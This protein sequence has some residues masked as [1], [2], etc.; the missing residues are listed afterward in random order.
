MSGN[1]GTVVSGLEPLIKICLS[2]KKPLFMSDPHSVERGA[3]SAYAYDQ[4]KI[5]QQGGSHGGKNP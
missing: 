1:Y 4:R 2:F 3:F 5:G